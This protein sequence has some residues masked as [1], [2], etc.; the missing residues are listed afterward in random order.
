[1]AAPAETRR[2]PEAAVPALADALV[3]ALAPDRVLS[4]ADVRHRHGSDESFHPAAPPDL[5]A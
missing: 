2:L 5:V 1:M 4:G 3:A